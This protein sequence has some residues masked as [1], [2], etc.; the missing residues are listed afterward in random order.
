MR[1]P[2]IF[3]NST[4]Y[5]LITVLQKGISFFLLP[6]YTAFLSPGDYGVIGVVGSVSAFLS[7]LLTLGIG[8]A[9]SRFY[10][11]S[12]DDEYRRNLY[13][14]IAIVIFGNCTFWGTL[15][16]LGHTVLVDPF[17]GKISFYPYVFIGLLNSIFTPIY[18]FYQNYLQTSQQAEKY[19]VI[20][21]LFFLLNISLILISL[22]VLHWGV[23][24]VLLANLTT[25]I[26]FFL[27]VLITFLPKLILKFNNQIF[28]GWAKYTLPLLPHSL[29]NWSNGMLDRLL[30]NGI[31]SQVD[32]GLYNLGQ[33]YGSVVSSIA[34]GINQAYVPWFFERI[35]NGRDGRK[36]IRLLGEVASWGIS[37][38]G[39]VLAIFAKE[40]LGV[41]IHNP[42]YSQVWTIIPCIVFAYVFQSLYYFFVNVLFIKDTKYVFIITML[43]VAINI[44]LNLLLIPRYGFMGCAGACVVTYF[45]KSI[46][47][48]IASHLCNK[49]ISFNWISMYL[50][51]LFAFAISLTPLWMSNISMMNALIIK[52]LLC[53][54]FFLYVL[55]RYRTRIY[56]I[57]NQIVKK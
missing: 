54:S 51:S 35:S 56:M 36:D 48:L 37:L 15:F 41:M 46:I 39:L 12:S 33:Q 31:K 29:A 8:G 30:V 13:G 3:K 19:G 55:I 21:I 49:E 5:T 24:G 16:I 25:S 7:V 27:Y 4:I 18:L 10:Y 50:S 47:A 52:T 20:S 44:G 14:T 2:G 23:L 1:I 57:F 34:L 22:C 43:T 53:F 17:I 26:V 38:I 42:A 32:A 28:K 6:V 45:V 9:M 40:I 11:K